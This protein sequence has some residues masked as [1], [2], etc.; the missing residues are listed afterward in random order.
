[1][2][3]KVNLEEL[4]KTIDFETVG[5]KLLGLAE[6]GGF[7]RRKN[8]ANLLDKVREALLKAR[9]SGVGVAALG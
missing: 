4:E 9:E 8:V 1:M 7:R 5:K 6:S 3:T 2:K